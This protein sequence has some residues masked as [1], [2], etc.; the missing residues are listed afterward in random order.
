MGS[1]QQVTLKKLKVGWSSVLKLWSMREAKHSIVLW[2]NWAWFL[3]FGHDRWHH[4]VSIH[5]HKSNW[6]TRR[7]R[8]ASCCRTQHQINLTPSQPLIRV[9]VRQGSSVKN[10]SGW[11]VGQLSI[12]LSQEIVWILRVVAGLKTTL[13]LMMDEF[14]LH[15]QSSFSPEPKF[16]RTNFCLEQSSVVW[17]VKGEEGIYGQG[18]PPGTALARSSHSYLCFLIRSRP[19]IKLFHNTSSDS[20][21][22]VRIF[23]PSSHLLTRLVMTSFSQMVLSSRFF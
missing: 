21:N 3:S 9:C 1:K 11:R 8:K 6:W 14:G 18:C 20:S 7:G 19:T 15:S 5:P 2:A 4:Q 22:Y 13:S 16:F 23:K 17:K 12:N 10:H